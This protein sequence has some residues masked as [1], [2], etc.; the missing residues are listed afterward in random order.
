PYVLRYGRRYLREMP[1]YPLPTD[2]PELQR[3]NMQTLLA[4]S[5]FG[6]P[7]CGPAFSAAADGGA[8]P[9]RV[10]ELACGSAYW[11]SLCAEYLARGR[12]ERDVTFVGVDVVQLAPDLSRQGIRWRFVRHDL[13]K[14]PLPFDDGDFDLVMMKDLSWVMPIGLPSQRLLDECIRVLRP[15]GTL[16]VWETDHVVRSLAPHPPP[17]PS[18]QAGRRAE[19][20]RCAAQTATFPISPATPFTTAHNGF[21]QDANAWIQDALDRRKLPPTPCTRVSQMLLQEPESLTDIDC[22]RVAVPLGEPRWEQAEGVATGTRSRKNSE[23]GAGAGA[24]AVG[25]GG[26]GAG[27]RAAKSLLTEEQQAL[28]HL[29]LLNVVQKIESLEPLLKEVSGKNQEEWQRWWSWMM[30]DLLENKGAS[31][32]ECLE[33]GAWWARK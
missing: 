6:R 5:V 7:L 4:T 18:G 21:L 20:D 3:Q 25:G 15:G 16:E 11:T 14:V 13:R 17:T 22:R 30:A 19:D 9:K 32:G 33:L 12:G 28:R 23:A 24:G 1:L 27:T 29:A 2:L 10:L 8:R 31:S 26:V